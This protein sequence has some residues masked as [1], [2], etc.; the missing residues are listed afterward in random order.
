MAVRT[1]QVTDDPMDIRCQMPVVCSSATTSRAS[2]VKVRNT[3][4][5]MASASRPV[6]QLSHAGLRR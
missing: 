1:N 4:P 2:E 5:T 6:A 3:P